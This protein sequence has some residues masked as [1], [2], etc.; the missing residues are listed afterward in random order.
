VSDDTWIEMD[1]RTGY[2]IV[3]AEAKDKQLDKATVIINRTEGKVVK[4]LSL[5]PMNIL[6]NP[7]RP[8]LYLS[9]WQSSSNEIIAY[10][11]ETFEISNRTPISERV[12]RMA[13]LEPVNELLVTIPSKSIIHRLDAETLGIKGKIRSSLGVRTL[14]VDEKRN[15]LLTLSLVSGMLDV[16]DLNTY[17]SIKRYYLAPW[18][19]S[20]VLDGRGAAYV[21][22]FRGLFKIQYD[23]PV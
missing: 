4:E 6:L 10:D 9:W 1:M 22:S 18:L 11:L 13:F 2:I 15:L 12:D 16:I 21:S 7:S 17:E 5:A 14:A 20:I 3:A 8:L 19:R 23:K